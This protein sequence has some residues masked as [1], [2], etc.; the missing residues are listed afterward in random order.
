VRNPAGDGAAGA[1]V[2]LKNDG[3]SITKTT[4]TRGDGSYIFSPVKIGVYS[5]SVELQGFVPTFQGSVIVDLQQR[6]VVNF[7][8]VATQ[9]GSGAAVSSGSSASYKHELA[10]NVLTA[11]T[12]QNLPINNR[13][14]TLLA[15]LVPGTSP[16]VQAPGGQTFIS[17]R[18]LIYLSQAIS[19][20][21]PRLTTATDVQATASLAATGSFAANGNPSYEA[22]YL[23]DGADDNTWFP[24]FLPGTA[25]QVLPAMD[26]IEE[27]KVD[28]PNYD[29]TMGGASG[30]IINVRTKSGTNEFHGDAWDYFGNDA[31]NAADYF[32]NASGLKR[33][34]LRKNVFGATLG[35]PVDLGN[36]YNGKNKTFFFASYQGAKIRQGVPSVTTVPTV[37]ERNSGYT[38]FSDLLSGQP[39]CTSGPDVLGRTVNCGTILDPATTRLLATGQVDPVTKL[40]P[41]STG[42]AREAFASNKIPA[43]RIDPVAAS[44]LNLFPVPTLATL[45]NNYTTNAYSRSDS[46]QFDVRVDHYFSDHNQVFGRFSWLDDPSL[47]DGPFLGYADGGGFS[48]TPTV[49]NGVLAITHVTSPTLIHDFRLTANRMALQR[50][51]AFGNDLTDV[52]AELGIFGIP[53]FTGNGGLP[54]INVGIY[55]QLGSSPYMP[56]IDYNTTYAIKEGFTKIRNG[57]I[58]KGGAEVMQVKAATSEPPYSRGDFDFAGNYT[59]IPNALDAST[60][61]AQF[62]LTPQKS[63]V[64][65]GRDYVGGPN[66]VMASNISNTYADLRRL[67]Y[68]AYLQDQ[69]KYSPQL[70]ITLGGRWEYFQPWKEQ[71]SAEAN[72]VPGS[73]GNAKYLIPA[74]RGFDTLPCGPQYPTTCVASYIN[75]LSTGFTDALTDDSISLDYP[76]RGALI[77]VRK[78]NFAP[79]LGFAYQYSPQIVVR[80]GAGIY[81]GG[82][83][84]EG[85]QANFGGNYPFQVNYDYTSPDDGSPI[86]YPSTSSYATL[87]QGLAPIPLTPQAATANELE[88][89][90]IQQSFNTPYTESGNLTLQYERPNHDLIELTYV[91]TLG[92]HLLIDP[93]VNQVGEILPAF[94][95]R[96]AYEPYLNFAYSSSYLETEGNSKYNS[97]RVQYVRHMAQGLSFIANYTYATTRTDALDFFNSASPQTYRA[98]AIQAFGITGDYQQ[99]DF[100]VR[101]AVHFSGSYELPFGPGKQ[102]L[103]EKDAIEGK[104]LGGWTLSWIATVQS[105]QPVTI[106]C[107]ITTASGVGCDALMVNGENVNGGPHNANQY[108]N[109]AA[110]YNPTAATSTG[111]NN[112]EPLGGA[113]TQVYGP[114]LRRLDAALQRSF[115]VTEN[116][117][118]VVR[119]EVYNAPNHPWFAQPSNLNFLNTSVFGQIS[120]TRDNP[121]D[122]RQIQFAVKFYF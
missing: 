57:H 66:Q 103:A 96:Q 115:Q 112:L 16:A 70:T 30:P 49:V 32:D 18:N 19:G 50:V 73:S 6:V 8:L 64:S 87:E 111:Q 33:A 72:F 120:S 44:L 46:N 7:Q 109:P 105:G 99:A 122:A 39:N 52:P 75:T 79:R 101:N 59:S 81:Y 114:P 95:Q 60:G 82:L 36:F 23:L 58:F 97:G 26:A 1:K 107:S 10:E 56:A 117:R 37:A 65:F 15:Q 69:W 94:Q 42:Y 45:Y 34:I 4:Y 9:S 2:Y 80:G 108:W 104:I 47:Q 25:Y 11:D 92:H 68:S 76:R 88:L 54:A 84:N 118:A 67:Y 3:T 102:L 89:R 48:Q 20:S 78:R 71:W 21:N 24:D 17:N 119:A 93:G 22:S 113:P 13:N 43:N 12:I 77:Q 74:G 116:I 90:G 14:L 98:P 83:E 63:S 29:T 61:V 86:V 5:V 35:G 53:Q 27:L 28:T 100:N 110:F 55:S 38:D 31:T 41:S 91:T 62:L 40:V 51:Q 85:A 121:N 106:P